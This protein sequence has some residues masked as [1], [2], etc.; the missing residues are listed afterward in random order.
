MK[1][2]GQAPEKENQLLESIFTKEFDRRSFLE[3]T[4]KIAGA[5]FGLSL[6]NS[7]ANTPVKAEPSAPVPLSSNQKKL[8]TIHFNSTEELARY[9]RLS[10]LQ[11]TQPLVM[12]HRAGY[13]PQGIWP[14]SALESAQHVLETGPAFVE[15]DLRTTSD[16]EIIMSHDDTLDR[17]TTGSGKVAET[18]YLEISKLY[19]RDFVGNRTEFKVRTFDEFLEWSRIGALLWLD[20]KDADPAKVVAKIRKHRAEARVIVSAYGVEKVRAFQ[21]LAPDLVYFIPRIPA[22][23]LPTTKSI[24]KNVSDPNRVIGMAGW[25]VPNIDEA[26]EMRHHDIP[27]LLELS[28]LDHGLTPDT[29]DPQLYKTAVAEGFPMF[30]TD[31]YAKVLN[32]LGI[33]DWASK[34]PRRQPR[35]ESEAKDN[36]VGDGKQD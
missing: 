24:L 36:R 27:G 13:S 25:Y 16:G 15:I 6:I 30:N 28:P 5:A 34:S 3:K 33:T 11:A 8:H 20:V 35:P 9:T 2:D 17:G 29:L 31:H 23:G 19:Q 22:L 26:M 32:I 4:T 7:L 18:S 10:S 21:K 1:R 12:A 14:E